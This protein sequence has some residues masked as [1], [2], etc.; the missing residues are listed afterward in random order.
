M[1]I[2]TVGALVVVPRETG[3]DNGLTERLGVGV[4]DAAGSARPLAPLAASAGALRH[5]PCPASVGVVPDTGCPLLPGRV[6]GD[7]LGVSIGFHALGDPP[8]R[9]A[10]DLADVAALGVGWARVDVDWAAVESTRGVDDWSFVDR[11]IDDAAANGLRVLGVLAYTP[12][13][14]RP[15]GTSDKHAPD[16]LAPFAAFAQRAAARYATRGIGA[17]EIWNEP[18]FVVN[19][20]PVPDAA[21]Y[22]AMVNAVGPA[23]RSVAPAGTVV[24][25]GGLAPAVDAPDGTEIAPETFVSRMLAAGATAFDAVGSHAYSYPDLPSDPATAS[26]NS[27]YRLPILHDAMAAAGFGARSVW[28]TEVGAPTGRTSRSVSEARQAE[29]VADAARFAQTF[30]FVVRT[31]FYSHRD[32]APATNTDPETQFG[33][34]RVDGSHKPAWDALAAIAQR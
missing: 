2:A 3:A 32:V 26:F 1:A 9:V 18:N 34:S 11:A 20:Q 7:K 12:P 24:V 31:F 28:I 21:R 13:W 6:A 10:A 19:W 33:L 30:P 8:E 15:A 23:I 29:I 5:G 27:F 14:A 17:W 25:T 22:A 4:A 16:D